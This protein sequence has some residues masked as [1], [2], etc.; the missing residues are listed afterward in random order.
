MDGDEQMIT[1]INAEMAIQTFEL[2]KMYN[3]ELEVNALD[4]NVPRGSVFGFLGLNGAGKTTTVKMLLN[5]VYPT[6]GRGQVLGHDIV[7]QSLNVREKVGFVGEEPLM[8]DYMK[9]SEIVSFCRDTYPNWDMKTVGK[10]LDLFELP[11]G[12]KVR[13]LSKGMK[14]QLALAV[15]LGNRPELL[16]LDEPTGGLDPVKT[17]DFY[18]VILEQV[19]ETGQTVF[20]SSHNLFEVER[21]ADT[22]G[23]IH[24]GRMVFHMEIDKIKENLKKIRVVFR[25]ESTGQNLEQLPGVT[26][27][28]RQGRGYVIECDSNLP[29]IT[30]KLN[31]MVP[32]DLEVIDTGLEEVFIRYT[33]GGLNG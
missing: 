16:I 19:A 5:L 14:N 25:E 26:G 2:T 3:N 6:S 33:G 7:S 20:F 4:L 17:R 15:G 10:Y 23:I 18:R 29:E 8:Y 22:V 24:K 9:V 28:S 12:K 13:E 27:V 30:A 31:E 1:E 11:V 32:L 21:V